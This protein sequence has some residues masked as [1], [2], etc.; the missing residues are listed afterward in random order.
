MARL[1]SYLLSVFLI[2]NLLVLTAC[3]NLPQATAQPRL[4]RDLSLEFLGEYDL[5]KQTLDGTTVGGLSGIT[6]D[7]QQD[8]F[9]AV[10]DDRQEPRV[11]SLRLGLTS[12]PEGE[13]LKGVT[14][15]KVML[16]RDEQGQPYGPDQL[17]TEGIALSPQ[18]TL[19][20][21]SEGLT[22]LNI[23]PLIGEFDRNTGKL[24]TKLPLP[25]RF[26]P[27]KDQGVQDNLGFESLALGASSTLADDPFRLFTALEN[28]LLQD[29]N[30]E[31]PSWRSPLR[32][33]HYVINPIGEPVLVGENVYQLEPAPSGTLSHGLT[34]ILTLPQ[35]GY[36]LTLERSFGLAGFDAKLFQV[37]NANA[38]DSSRQGSLQGDL[39][40]VEGLQKKL[41]LDLASLGLDLDNLEAMALGPQLKDGS[42][43]LVLVSDDNFNVDQVTQFLLFRL[44]LG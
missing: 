1:I 23:P 5:P 43:S 27:G 3:A 7:R 15:E 14:V 44:R 42:Q 13:T 38:T 35:E 31:I 40:R 4:F 29:L 37:V 8:L 20:I 6:Y 39:S 41:L 22:K 30:P 36:F 9:Y 26:L 12:T 10:S 17:D 11:Y 24:L 33:L 21:A 2:L 19:F 34:E 28:A 32:W 16:L 25:Q 18:N